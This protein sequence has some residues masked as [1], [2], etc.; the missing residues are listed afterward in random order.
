MLARSRIRVSA[1]SLHTTI[2]RKDLVGPPDRISHIRPIIYDDAP[3]A[4]SESRHPYSLGEFTGDTREYQWKIQRQQLDTFNHEYWLD[5]NTRFE[6]GQQAVL[7]NLPSTASAEDREIALS[8]YYKQWVAQE[9]ERQHAYSDEWRKRNWANI[10]LG[11][12]LKYRMLWSRLSRQE[13][14]SQ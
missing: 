11:A 8:Q 1:R 12:K 9:S 7:D 4:P 14:H 2:S 5:S 3:P 10:F 6:A 13:V